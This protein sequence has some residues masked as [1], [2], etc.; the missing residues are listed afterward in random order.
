[1]DAS[2]RSECLPE[3]RIDLIRLI[4][5]WTEDTSVQ[6]SIFWLQGLAGAG[7]STLST[8]LANRLRT[9]GRLGAFLFFDRDVIRRND[10]KL[11]ISNGI[12]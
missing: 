11:V 9:A 5:D 4:E 10:P 3:T 7:K 12:F 6:Q 1:M 2:D 8:T